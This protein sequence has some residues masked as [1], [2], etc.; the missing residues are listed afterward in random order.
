MSSPSNPAESSPYCAAD[1][2]ALLDVAR[3]SIGYYLDHRRPLPIAVG[4]YASPLQQHR[5]SFVTLKISGE[6][7]GCIGTL[8]ARQALVADVVDN[9][10]SAAFRDPR[11][12]PLSP[13]EFPEIDIHISVL[14]PPQPMAATSEQDLLDQTLDL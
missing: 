2:A 8:T 4:D 7:R 11:F 14:S 12:P 9:A 10:V 1:R 13:A 5:A 3:Q 6:L